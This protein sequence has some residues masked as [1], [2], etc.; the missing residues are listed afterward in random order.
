MFALVPSG[1]FTG[2]VFFHQCLFAT[3]KTN[4]TPFYLRL[5]WN[6]SNLR[7]LLLVSTIVEEVRCPSE[8]S[9]SY[10]DQDVGLVCGMGKGATGWQA[11]L[12]FM[13]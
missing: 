7:F 6:Q 4:V 2:R 5:V 1:Q 13:V 11:G 3:P 12:A 8:L 10:D 9:G